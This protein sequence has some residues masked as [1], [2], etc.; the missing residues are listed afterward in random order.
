MIAVDLAAAQALG[1]DIRA[2]CSFSTLG[3]ELAAH[4][5]ALTL[6]V[7]NPAFPGA[8][9]P[10][11]GT[12][13][14]LRVFVAASTINDWRRLRP[15][16]QA[17]AGATLTSFDGIPEA[18]PPDDQIAAAIADTKPA[19]T[20]VI[21]VPFDSNARLAALRALVRAVDTLSQAPNLQR[22]VPEPTSWLLARF[23]DQLNVGRRDAATD[24]L[25][26]LKRE[27]RLDS[28]NLQFL[29]VQLYAG[30]NDWPAIVTMPA[31]ASLCQ[32]RRT[33][34]ITAILLEALYEVYLAI[35]FDAHD[36]EG[37][38]AHFEA[39]VRPLARPL[40]TTPAPMTLTVAGWRIFGLEIWAA[41]SRIDLARELSERCGHLGWIADY[42]PALATETTPGAALEPAPIDKARD[43]LV[44]VDTIESVGSLAAAK[45]ALAKLT[46]EE[47]AALR[48]TETFRPL[49]QTAEQSNNE[50]LPTTWVDWFDKAADPNFADALDIARQ[51]KDEWS[52]KANVGDPISTQAL[53][54]AL[55]RAQSNNLAAERTAQALPFLVA[56]LRRDLEFPRPAMMPIYGSLLTLL[57]LGSARGNATYESSQILINA[58]LTVGLDGRAYRALI[59]DIE[60]L[61]GEGF[62]VSM[63]Y[64]IL[65]IVEDFMVASTPDSSARQNFLHATLSRI[66]P[67]FSRLSSLQRA[68]VAQLADELGWT[69]QSIGITPHSL[70]SDNLGEKLKGLRIGIYSLTEKA[71]RQAKTAIEEV[72]PNAIVDCNADYGGTVKL[73]SLAEN[74]DLFVL[75]WL[76]AKHA[77]T[78]FIRAHRGGRPL[79]YAQGR[80]SSSILRVVED[81]FA[82]AL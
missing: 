18:L 6:T 46:P 30:F 4:C 55:D 51:G 21:R 27:L 80:G 47:L 43:A 59:A 81:Y 82:R 29:Q 68:A 5:N 58:L 35:Y 69:L 76:S 8:V 2:I 14:E 79:L 72:A 37:T 38:R 77:A 60:E 41:P 33:P 9:V 50:S 71:S 63:I 62:G 36:I 52:I 64:W 44:L 13:G 67:I 23:Q 73:R 24:I 78:D 10:N 56:W 66:S 45:E 1:D 42:L 48:E 26:R 12:S 11:I 39:S 34:A 28:L 3:A 65:E 7:S 16:L 70:V 40:L 32:A 75:T 31:F 54:C 25:E 19:T 15:I 57:A 53:V 20:A 49:L 17:F 22:A 61:A 74:A